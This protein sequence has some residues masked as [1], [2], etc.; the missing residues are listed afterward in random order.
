MTFDITQHVVLYILIQFIQLI[1]FDALLQEGKTAIDYIKL[2]GMEPLLDEV[3]DQLVCTLTYMMYD[4]FTNDVVF[5]MQSIDNGNSCY[6]LCMN[7]QP[8]N[9]PVQ[10][11][12]ILLS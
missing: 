10:S 3:E 4:N 5:L 1:L 12:L 2:Y 6:S 11:I 7:N 9:Q 8:G